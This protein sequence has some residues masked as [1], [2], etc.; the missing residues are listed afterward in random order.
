VEILFREEGKQ[1]VF[2]IREPIWIGEGT[3]WDGTN[4]SPE[5]SAFILQVNVFE[6]PPWVVT[7]DDGVEDA[8]GI[9]WLM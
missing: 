9:V 6:E 5:G 3:S 1:P 8:E 7:P 2:G 4:M